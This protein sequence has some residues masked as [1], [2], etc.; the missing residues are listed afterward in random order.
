MTRRG[1]PTLLAAPTP[2]EY[3]PK[4][5]RQPYS[6]TMMHR[7]LLWQFHNKLLPLQFETWRYE[8]AIQP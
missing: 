3:A 5:H 7:N 1:A 4:L 6:R 8:K 2:D